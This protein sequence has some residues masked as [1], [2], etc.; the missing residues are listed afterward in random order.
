MTALSLQDRAGWLCRLRV[1]DF[2]DDDLSASPLRV[3]EA[4]N[5]LMHGG[6]SLLWA[7]ARGAGTATAGQALTYL[8]AANAAIGAGNG[9]AAAAATQT[10]L[11]GASRLRRGMNSTYPQHSDGTGAGAHQIIFQATFGTG[12]ANFDWQEVSLHNSATDATGRMV[13]RIVQNIGVKTS[14]ISRVATMTL[15]LT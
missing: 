3:V 8:D 6:A 12:D 15:T 1:E 14:S 5:L 11:Q 9:T 2:P 7:C 13:N 10:D 4:S